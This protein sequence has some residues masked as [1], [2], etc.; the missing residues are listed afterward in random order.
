MNTVNNYSS[1]NRI[2]GMATGMDTDAM[3]KAMTANYQLKID[4]MN[5][6]KQIVQWK[7]EFYREII[8]DIKGLQD[9]FDPVSDKYIMSASKFNPMNVTNSNEGALG[10]SAS[11]TAQKG[12]YKI[13]ISQLA[14]P[15]VVEG[16]V[17]N[18]TNGVNTKLTDLGIANDSSV[19]FKIGIDSDGNGT[20]DDRDDYTEIKT[21]NIT[22]D[23]NT[24]IKSVIDNINADLGGKVNASFDELSKK[25]VFSTATTGSNSKLSVEGSALGFTTGSIV[26]KPGE[27]ANF[28]ITYPDGR[29]VTVTD[30][31][32]NKFTA[33]GIT[34]DLKAA[35]TGDIT[36]SIEK[37]NTDEVVKKLKTF[38]DDYNKIIGKIEDKLTEKKQ[39]SYKPLTDE[40]KKDM[41]DDDI[42][43][44]EEKAKQGILKNDDYLEQLMS[45]LRGTIFD[46]VYSNKASNQKN[47]LHMGQYGDGAIG[48]DTSREFKERGQIFIKDEEKLKSA[49]ENNIEDL[50]KFFIGKSSTKEDTDKYIGTNTYYEDGLF[51]R[52]D[53][54]I[55]Q[56]AGDPAIGKDGMSTLK[57]TLNIQANKQ[58]DYSITGSTGKNTMPDKIYSKILSI[59]EL[60]KKMSQ[61]QERYYAKFARLETAMNKLNSQ[62]NSMY[63]QFG[64]NG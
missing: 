54:I 50:T 8:K 30:Q 18:A 10:I 51:T 12:S 25:I 58:Y 36:F 24:T 37:N 6:D 59:G 29:G 28:T 62:M 49:I 22:V 52:M 3:V 38:L 17:V 47:S 40:Q 39:F 34:Y 33:N 56:Y 21:S 20:V 7:Q 2:T 35:G 46:T 1:M 27:N 32:T 61:A 53:K 44:W 57:G 15:A 42:K 55:R 5:E 14:K 11:S 45:D 23:E 16:G 60:E 9:Y 41:K 4:K 13:N 43:K 31:K 26:T 63:S 64:M 48:L 19:Q